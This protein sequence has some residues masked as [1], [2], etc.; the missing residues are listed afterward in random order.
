MKTQ[1]QLRKERERITTELWKIFCI[2]DKARSLGLHTKN[3][4]PPTPRNL[5]SQTVKIK[6]AAHRLINL[7]Q[8]IN[9][10]GYGRQRG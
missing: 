6:V 9:I 5:A 7:H 8:R 10:H 1:L 2:V 4:I 3:I